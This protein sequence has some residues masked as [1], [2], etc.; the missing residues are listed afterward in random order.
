MPQDAFSVSGR[1]HAFGNPAAISGV[2]L[3]LGIKMWF[4]RLSINGSFQQPLFC[5][6]FADMNISRT[7]E[8]KSG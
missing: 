4:A 7:F 1:Y 2:E 3:V 5:L 6:D 8:R